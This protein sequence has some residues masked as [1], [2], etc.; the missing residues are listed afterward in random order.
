MNSNRDLI[1]QLE[2][3]INSR[4]RLIFFNTAEEERAETLL[5]LLADYMGLPFFNWSRS[6]GL[7]RDDNQNKG[8]IYNS[9]DIN[10]AIGHIEASSF[11]AIYHFEGMLNH[12]EDL[13]IVDKLRNTVLKL[14]KIN[15]AIILTGN[16][17]NIPEP[18]KIHS[19]ILNMPEPSIDEYRDLLTH[20]IRDLKFKN[21]LEVDIKPEEKTQL[22]NNIKGLTLTEAE[23]ILTKIMV[24]DN[25]LSN[26]DIRSVIE[27]KKDIIEKDGV[28]EYYPV[29]ESMGD[30]AGLNA[31]K[32]WLAKR[33]NIITDPGKAKEFG[34]EFPKG[35]LVLG[36]PG[37]GKSLCAKAVAMEWGLPLLKFDTA[38]LYNK[39]IGETEKNLKNA[40]ETSEKM[41]PVVLWIDEIE[42]AFTISGSGQDGGVSMRVFGTFLN[43][44]QER[45]GDVFIFATANDVSKLPPEFLRKGRFDEI[46]FVDLPDFESRK[47]IFDIHLKKRD[48]DSQKFDLDLLA[49]SSDGFSGSEIEQVVVSSLYTAF[50]EST[51]LSTEI[52]LNEIAKT[53]PLSVTMAERIYNLREWAEERTVSAH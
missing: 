36:V 37:C 43:W 42:K 14:S 44:M 4:Y 23:K 5:K 18:L 17:S 8:K 16:I 48:K 1:H 40:I 39:Y 34:L 13:N 46:F 19:T 50:S 27:E 24:V 52:L 32:D 26:E 2:V 53:S 22:L 35:I 41:S 31:L 51:E 25:T 45:K 29:E 21:N 49:N 38:N 11:P 12:L 20:I 15:G 7:V 10:I 9:E 33:K 3:T 6:K 30:I 47:I 28:L